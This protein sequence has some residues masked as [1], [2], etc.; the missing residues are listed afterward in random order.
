M[1]SFHTEKCCQLVNELKMSAE[2]LCKPIS[3][4]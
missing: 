1:T 2:H 4:L 3:D